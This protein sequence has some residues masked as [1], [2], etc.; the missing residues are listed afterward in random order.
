[1]LPKM[2]KN[3]SLAELKKDN[4]PV[5]SSLAS[6]VT[7]YSFLDYLRSQFRFNQSGFNLTNSFDQ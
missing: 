6:T 4:C 3:S 7:G 1:M 5:T 2:Q